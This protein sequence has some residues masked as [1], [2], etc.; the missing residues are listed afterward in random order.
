MF[1]GARNITQAVTVTLN[2]YSFTI[3][4]FN[5]CNAH[6]NVPGHRNMK[7]RGIDTALRE[8]SN[9][10]TFI[11]LFN[12]GRRGRACFQRKQ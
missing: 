10:E 2:S 4:Y 3:V 9:M 5:W 12:A 8:I 11:A 1:S 6:S 7:L